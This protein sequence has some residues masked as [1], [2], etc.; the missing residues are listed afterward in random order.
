VDGGSNVITIAKRVELSNEDF[1]RGIF[2]TEWKRA[3]TTSFKE[4]PY[5]LDTLNLRHYWGGGPAETQLQY[6]TEDRNTY[7]VISLFELAD[8]GRAR[9]RKDLHDATYVI[10]IDD[11]HDK[12]PAENLKDLP[13]PSYKLETSPGNEQW[14]YLLETPET[15]QERIDALL[16]GLVAAGIADDMKDPG[17]KGVTRYVRMP[18]G[19]NT[20][21][22]YNAV[23]KCKL[24]VWE[25]TR[26]FQLE[27]LARPFGIDVTNVSAQ[28]SR[29]GTGIP[30]TEDPIIPLLHQ[31]GVFKGKIK[32]GTYDVECPWIDEHTGAADSGAAYLSPFGFRCHHGS[33]DDRHFGHVLDYLEENITGAK[34][35]VQWAQMVHE[36]D[37]ESRW[38]FTIAKTWRTKDVIEEH[39]G[40]LTHLQTL[41]PARY[42]SLVEQWDI[43]CGVSGSVIADIERGAEAEHEHRNT[44]GLGVLRPSDWAG[45]PTPVRDWVVDDWLPRGKVTSL[46]GDGGLGK[47]LLAQMLATSLSRGDD[48]LGERTKKT[49]VLCV[50]CEDD[51]EEM[52]RRQDDIN[53]KFVL[54]MNSWDDDDSLFYM[55]REGEDNLLMTFDKQ[56]LGTL[57]NFWAK[58]RDT[59]V[60]FDAEVVILDTLADIFGGNEINRLEVR[61]FVQRA[62]LGLAQSINGSVLFLA[63][64]S[65]AGKSSGQGF[66]GSTA[67]NNSVRSRWYLSSMDEDDS[68]G[69]YRRLSRVKSNYSASGSDT[70]K[71]LEWERGVF[72]VVRSAEDGEVDETTGKSQNDVEI[73]KIIIDGVLLADRQK[74][75]LGKKKG[76][77]TAYLADWCRH[78]ISRA[79]IYTVSM[80]DQVMRR[81]LVEGELVE[82]VEKSWRTDGGTGRNKARGIGYVDLD[83]AGAAR[84][85]INPFS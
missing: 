59:A 4:D 11:V 12:V 20:K 85:E 17:M 30:E 7:F 44:G 81:M 42:D 39:A 53:R 77:R 6:C 67:W 60:A 72:R 80:I 22:K 62:L 38:P 9:R 41:D 74:V 18:V 43:V 83:S 15:R 27:D 50:L 48:W 69:N 3:H 23:Y 2:G 14:G 47:T 55:C 51:E 45:R 13:E 33:H 58:L 5:D 25:P 46:Y 78:E 75:T 66:S 29:Y 56:S 73:G 40:W 1:L 31:A 64:P 21:K 71:I 68:R 65:Q 24:T 54:D 70:D 19:S 52:W 35:S 63:H 32:P 82:G 28:T 8:D 37:E 76:A 61:Q 34:K 10:T 79:D 49:R 36:F 16:N 84:D 26:K 57:T